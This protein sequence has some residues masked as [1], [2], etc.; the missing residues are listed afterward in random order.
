MKK[1]I[2]LAKRPDLVQKLEK[3]DLIPKRKK[4]GIYEG[5]AKRWA[6]ERTPP[7]DTAEYQALAER[8]PTGWEE[9]T[10][11]EMSELLKML[12][13]KIS[14]K[15]IGQ[16]D[17]PNKGAEKMLKNLTQVAF[18]GIVTMATLLTE[19]GIETLPDSKEKEKGIAQELSFELVLH[20][21]NGTDFL[22]Q[23]FR[24]I[25][26]TT[27]TSK[28]NQEIIAEFLKVTAIFLAILTA[29]NGQ[30]DKLKKQIMAFKPTFSKGIN[31]TEDFVSKK[32]IEETIGGEEAESIALYLQQAK[33][34]LNQDDF[35][36]FYEAFTGALGALNLSPDNFINDVKGV[37]RFTKELRQ[38]I[39][40]NVDN[41]TN[42][43]TAISQA[44]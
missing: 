30:E 5:C 43:I 34:A 10:N 29:S 9:L 1:T 38:L 2:I 14:K 23:I 40:S 17:T 31:Q 32:L 37:R 19:E 24:T 25:A 7:Y 15:K 35:D 44:M 16:L 28:K 20:L 11:E 26:E 4:G 22:T 13:I 33:I 8:L 18:L 6:K 12:E 41:E 42:Q 36:G 21:I 3:Y 27:R 39:N